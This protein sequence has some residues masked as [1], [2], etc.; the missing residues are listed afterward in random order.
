MI[1]EFVN[2]Q[3]TKEICN[4]SN[5]HDLCP[6]E[7]DEINKIIV[8]DKVWW[9]E[10]LFEIS[11]EQA[12]AR[13]KFLGYELILH[14]NFAKTSR[15]IVKNDLF[16]YL[17][18]LFLEQFDA[19]HWLNCLF[20]QSDFRI[21][22]LT[23]ALIK[24]LQEKSLLFNCGRQ[25]KISTLLG[26]IESNACWKQCCDAL[27]SVG[28]ECF[29]KL[30]Q[31]SGK[32]DREVVPISTLSELLAYLINSKTLLKCYQKFTD[33]NAIGI[34]N[35]IYLVIRPWNDRINENNEFR[36]F[37]YK[38]KIT[39]VSQQKWFSRIPF[40]FPIESMVDSLQFKIDQLTHLPYDSCVFDVYYDVTKNE[41]EFIEINPWGNW[42]AAG[43][44]LFHWLKDEKI[45]YSQTADVVVRLFK[46]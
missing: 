37:Y 14:E 19:Q 16:W 23:S 42:N 6:F 40:N 2:D 29:V 1:L 28:T 30:S 41:T 4:T 20:P 13:V 17:Y 43:S 3:P 35:E 34:P 32:H 26:D 36:V 9:N 44:S 21:V 15:T 24:F 10:E 5:H 22:K 31:T 12:T 33:S 45:L 38:N 8:I 25:L 46:E 7:I 11:R 18:L 27:A 39:A